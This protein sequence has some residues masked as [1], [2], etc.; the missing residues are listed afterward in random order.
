[1]VP[2]LAISSCFFSAVM[3]KAHYPPV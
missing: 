2:Y 3:D 1:L